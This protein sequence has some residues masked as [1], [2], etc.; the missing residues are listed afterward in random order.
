MRR[1]DSPR[2][3]YGF[4]A[5]LIGLLG[6]ILTGC[7]SSAVS[8]ERPSLDGPVKFS[9]AEVAQQAG[10]E[11]ARD[12]M[13]LI[14]AGNWLQNLG[15]VE[16]VLQSADLFDG[17]VDGTVAEV[18]EARV[19]PQNL[20]GKKAEAWGVG[21]LSKRGPRKSW[22]MA[23]PIEDYLIAPA[24]TVVLFLKVV[25]HDSTQMSRW[26]K[27][28]LSYSSAGRDYVTESNFGFYV[29]AAAFCEDG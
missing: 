7:S 11:E 18:V 3:R 14:F 27:T 16:A 29:C 5:G 25:V 15:S 2:S 21:D 6:A 20:V 13:E 12:D 1:T 23:E 10:F 4:A 22:E 24:E 8:S 19:L 17:D 28:E 26:H 9:G